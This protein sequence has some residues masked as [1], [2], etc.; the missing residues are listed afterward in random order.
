VIAANPFAFIRG[1]TRVTVADSIF[2]SNVFVTPFS[3][4]ALFDTTRGT[5]IRCVFLNN[6]VPAAAGGN[7]RYLLLSCSAVAAVGWFFDVSTLACGVGFCG[8]LVGWGWYSYLCAIDVLVSYLHTVLL[9][10]C[11]CCCVLPLC[12]CCCFVVLCFVV[13]VLLLLLLLLFLLSCCC[14]CFV[15][16][17]F[18][19]SYCYE[20]Q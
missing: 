13:I 2:V 12:C 15:L 18:C 19:C 9:L 7:L 11:Y 5:F 17:C 8:W 6:F 14:F 20:W 3:G 4:A 10:L 16:F 1:P